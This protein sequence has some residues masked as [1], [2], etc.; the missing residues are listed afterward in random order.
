MSQSI[1]EQVLELAKTMTT[2]QMVYHFEKRGLRNDLVSAIPSMPRGHK[3]AFSDCMKVA[4][5]RMDVERPEDAN[6]DVIQEILG[7]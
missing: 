5:P 2:Q 7:R 6:I 3:E 1:I 4:V